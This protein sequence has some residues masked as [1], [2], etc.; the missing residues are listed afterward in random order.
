MIKFQLFDSENSYQCHFSEIAT[1][2]VSIAHYMRAYFNYQAL[3]HGKDFEL[4]GDA[5]YLNVSRTPCTEQS[6]PALFVCPHSL[7]LL[8]ST[9]N[10]SAFQ[11][12][13]LQ[14]TVHSDVPLYAKI[15]CM[16]RETF[17]ST[18]LQLHVYTDNQ[19]SQPFDDGQN[20]RR[21]V[22]KGY[23]LNGYIFPTRVSFRP[24]FY[25]C[26][27]CSPTEIS[28]TYNKQ[29][30]NWY[31]DYYISQNG[32]KNGNNNGN[33]NGNNNDAYQ[34]ANDDVPRDDDTYYN[35]YGYN[36][37]SFQNDDDDYYKADDNANANNDDNNR[38]RHRNLESREFTRSIAAAAPGQLEVSS[39]RTSCQIRKQ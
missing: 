23:D 36:Y 5:G 8:V 12:V 14:E 7:L 34:R 4:P 31:D 28:E 15:G 27:S 16:D 32:Q 11:C 2:V 35:P 3:L 9:W 30:G 10:Q 20:S 38:Q 21:R 22:S 17:T 26:D 13:M 29:Y 25:T 18:K 19:C 33:Y 1:F 6:L 39:M 24:N 37:N